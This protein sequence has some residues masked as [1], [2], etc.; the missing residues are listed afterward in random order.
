M[1][2][3][4]QLAPLFP[5]VD[6]I[7][8]LRRIIAIVGTPNAATLAAVCEPSM[9]SWMTTDAHMACVLF[10]TGA[11]EFIMELEDSPGADFNEL[12]GYKNDPVTQ[13][14]QSGVSAE[15]ELL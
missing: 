10:V 13:E 14:R 9:S 6:Y 11:Q 12:F 4:I 5:G 2:E 3:L 1:G 7:D 15:G 8:Q